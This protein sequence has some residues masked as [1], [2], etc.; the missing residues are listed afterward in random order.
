VNFL[1]K[2]ALCVVEHGSPELE[3]VGVVE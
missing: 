3:I 1:A 2:A